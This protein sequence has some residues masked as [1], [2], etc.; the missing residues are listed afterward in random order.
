MINIGIIRFN[1]GNYGGIEQQIIN[2]VSNM[3]YNEFHFTLITNNNTQFSKK[4]EEYGEVCYIKNRNIIRASKEVNKIVSEKKI[5][6]IQ[7]HMLREHYIGCLTKIINKNLYHI[8]RVHTYINC[9]FINKWK[10]KLYHILSFLLSRYVNIYLPINQYNANE[11]MKNSKI[12]KKKIK[13]VHDGV[14]GLNIDTQN[15]EFNY[16]DLAMIANLEYGK[17]HDIAIEALNI[18]L[19]EDAEYNLTIIGHEKNS[20]SSK[21]PITDSLKQLANKLGVENNIVF[22]GFT[23]NVGKAIENTD[24]VI[25]PSYSEGTPN[26]LL[27][28]M[29]VKK[30]VIASNVGGI[31][32]FITDGENGFLHE[33]KDY[34]GLAKKIFD[35]NRLT[36]EKR[37]TIV[38]NGYITWKNEYSVESLCNN[39]ANI[40][41]KNGV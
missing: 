17:G 19:K 31:P 16:K 24:I 40:Y 39:L 37:N 3:D 12:S 9:S 14:K 36:K 8:F 32:E 5:G 29:S 10:K 25:L 26:C 4:F 7:S 27:E 15:D 38:E 21:T 11:L 34:E 35:L 6:I 13:V 20:D 28:A 30:I 41:I 1:S 23:E 18:L 22:L 33:N 2:I